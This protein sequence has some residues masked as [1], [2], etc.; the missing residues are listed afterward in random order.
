MGCFMLGVCNAI[1]VNVNLHQKYVVF[2]LMFSLFL[3]VLLYGTKCGTVASLSTH[4]RL[5]PLVFQHNI[6]EVRIYGM[7]L[8]TRS[9][10]F[11]K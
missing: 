7:T 3:F 8:K 1:T 6:E 4:S 5:Y 9:L 2:Q 10:R 11:T